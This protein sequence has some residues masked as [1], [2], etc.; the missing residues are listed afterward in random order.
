[1]AAA[2]QLVERLGAN[3]A[4]PIEVIPFGW[5]AQA[6]F[7]ES[8][9]ASVTLR[10]HHDEAYLTD[11]GNHILDCHFGPIDDTQA[12]G[13]RMKMRTGI[14]EHG[15]FLGFTSDVLVAGPDGIRHLRREA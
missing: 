8:L 10:Q 7:L 15:L 2:Q 6:T 4:V 14:V 3:W 11:Q 5:Q 13:A 9:G 1:M 12:L